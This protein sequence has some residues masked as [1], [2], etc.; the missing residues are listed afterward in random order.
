MELSEHLEVM[1]HEICGN[2][3]VIE[4]SGYKVDGDNGIKNAVGLN[5]RRSVDYFCVIK[6]DCQFVEF[7]DL[8]R[9]KEDILGV[10]D[11]IARL[12]QTSRNILSK[13]IKQN[14][15]REMVEK[16]KDSKDIF[17][18]IPSVYDN[19]P[20]TFLSVESKIFYIVYA[21]ISEQLG[22][23]A[24]VEIARFLTTLQSSISDCLEADICHR[25]KVIIL[26]KFIQELKS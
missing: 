21:P 9:W 7:S 15:R 25:V 26:S 2:D 14:S 5:A 8:A 3:A 24:K 1:N 4:H 23:A 12:E 13:L 22:D 17:T 10:D 19:S 11:V 18:K 16:F 20:K 6:G